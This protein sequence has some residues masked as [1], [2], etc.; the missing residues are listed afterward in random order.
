M[1]DSTLLLINLLVAIVIIM[2]SILVFKWNPVVAL[3]CGSLY[4]GLASGLDLMETVTQITVGFG[5]LMAAIG[6][7]IAGDSKVKT[8]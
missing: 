2:A 4:M 7:S 3:V 5:D 8:K 1:E 6:L